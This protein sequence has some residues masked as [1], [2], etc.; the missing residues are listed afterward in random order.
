MRGRVQCEGVEWG[1]GWGARGRQTKRGEEGSGFS[2]EG[3]SA[4]IQRLAKGLPQ[5]M[6]LR[7]VVGQGGRS[8]S[9]F[10]C[11]SAFTSRLHRANGQVDEFHKRLDFLARPEGFEPRPT[12][13]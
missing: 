6:S 4:G 13:P 8:R 3:A 1:G 5:W 7:R 10:I 12:D 11:T 2:V 9:E